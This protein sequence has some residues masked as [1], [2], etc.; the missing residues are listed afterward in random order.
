MNPGN[1]CGMHSIFEKSTLACKLQPLDTMHRCKPHTC[2]MSVIDLIPFDFVSVN[3]SFVQRI[4]VCIQHGISPCNNT[5][6]PGIDASSDL[7]ANAFDNSVAFFIGVAIEIDLWNISVAQRTV[8]LATIDTTVQIIKSDAL[9]HAHGPI[10]YF[11]CRPVVDPQL[12][13]TPA[14]IDSCWSRTF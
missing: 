11:L 5:Y 8:S 7:I 13:G 1:R 4:F 6:F 10:T 12:T 14:N 3:T 2:H 9:Q